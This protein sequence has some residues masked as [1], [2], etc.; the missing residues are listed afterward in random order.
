MELPLINTIAQKRKEAYLIGFLVGVPV[1]I[2]FLF[3]NNWSVG[4]LL[5]SQT[6]WGLV[7]VDMILMKF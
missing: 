4:D 7:A 6:F 3:V 5:T 1:L 2:Y